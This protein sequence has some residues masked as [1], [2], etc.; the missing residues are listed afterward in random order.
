MTYLV[1]LAYGLADDRVVDGPKW[2]DVARF[3]VIARAD[4]SATTPELR[5]MLQQLLA[6]RFQIK[7][8]SDQ[9]P[10]PVYLLT[11]ARRGLRLKPSRS[12][13][14][15]DC[16]APAD[17][18]VN[19][20]CT[21][22]TTA[23]L[24]EILPTIAPAY[25]DAPIRDRTGASGRYDFVLQWT[26]RA[27]LAADPNALSLYDYLEKELGIHAEKGTEPMLAIH[28][29]S[30]RET[31]TPNAPN[32]RDTIPAPPSEF[33]AAEVRP[34]QSEGARSQFSSQNGCLLL[35]RFTAK[36]L[37]SFAYAVGQDSIVSGPAWLDTD[38]FLVVAK[39]DPAVSIAEIR[40]LLRKLL[41]DRFLPEVHTEDRPTPVYA[42]TATGSVHLTEGNAGAREGCRV[43]A[44]P[45]GRIYTCTNTTMAEFAARLNEYSPEYLDHPAIDLT[46][47]NGAYDF[48][49][50]W[51]PIPR[52]NAPPSPDPSGGITLAAGLA[53]IGLKLTPQKHSISV[54]A[55]DR[56]DRPANN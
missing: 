46:G 12:K 30:V 22:V 8:R 25:F 29:E 47:L 13:G 5:Q 24:A 51:T 9:A 35:E 1:A 49:I 56:L 42:L 21:G 43:S 7:V 54:V 41:A 31:P 11:P 52:T 33:E 27:T 48:T 23:R 37:V 26:G 4:H 40:P 39:T 15:G 18:S 44:D 34:D 14:D 16:V 6:D 45:K 10:A 36:G 32:L 55:I 2:I 20:V 53:K 17:H 50:S 3:D 28:V 38:R 19:R